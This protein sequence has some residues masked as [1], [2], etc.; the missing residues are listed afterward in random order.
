MISRK[1]SIGKTAYVR[2]VS[3][4]PQNVPVRFRKLSKT[5]HYEPSAIQA[6]TFSTSITRCQGSV[7]RVDLGG[8]G[9][10]RGRA[11]GRGHHFSRAQIRVGRMEPVA[12]RQDLQWS[13]VT[14][15]DW[16]ISSRVENGWRGEEKS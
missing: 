6:P 13:F 16:T 9:V 8:V 15:R 12:V 11:Q 10:R 3:R 4:Y 1:S 2:L 14:M 7:I 5:L